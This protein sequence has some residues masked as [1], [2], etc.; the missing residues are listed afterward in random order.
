MNSVLSKTISDILSQ[1]FNCKADIS[2]NE[3][4]VSLKDG[5][6]KVRV[7]ASGEMDEQELSKLL[8][9]LMMKK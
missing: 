2:L 5:N 7:D 9:G 8:S 6:A 3:L 1:K 4:E